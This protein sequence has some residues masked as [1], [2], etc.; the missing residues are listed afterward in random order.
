M[1]KTFGTLCWRFS[2]RYIRGGD[3]GWATDK[4]DGWGQI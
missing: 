3:A 1:I 4:E 2:A